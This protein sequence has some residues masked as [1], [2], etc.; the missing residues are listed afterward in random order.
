MRSVCLS[1]A[2]LRTNPSARVLAHSLTH[3]PTHLFTHSIIPSLT[4][5]SVNSRSGSC[6]SVIV[7]CQQHRYVRHRP[8][9]DA[10][11][12]CTITRHTSPITQPSCRMSASQEASQHWLRRWTLYR[13]ACRAYAP[14]A[15]AL[16]KPR[17]HTQLN[18]LRQGRPGRPWPS[19]MQEL[20]R[21]SVN[22]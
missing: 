18:P 10:R 9:T 7:A 4:H 16:A 19:S 17:P 3:P 11:N 14:A 15:P 13:C 21:S 2:H 8:R 20:C 22:A 1:A 6:H 12:S 5:T